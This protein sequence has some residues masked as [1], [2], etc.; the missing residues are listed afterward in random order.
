MF[1]TIKHVSFYPSLVMFII[2]VVLATTVPL[3]IYMFNPAIPL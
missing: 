3:E 1:F 2:K